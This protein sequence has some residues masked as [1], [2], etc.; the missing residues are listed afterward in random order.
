MRSLLSTIVYNGVHMNIKMC[1]V[2]RC[3]CILYVYDVS[4]FA[5][6]EDRRCAKKGKREESR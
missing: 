2:A 6:G 1:V 5:S 4:R 3:K